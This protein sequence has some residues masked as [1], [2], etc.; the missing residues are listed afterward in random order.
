MSAAGVRVKR[1]RLRWN[2]EVGPWGNGFDHGWRDAHRGVSFGGTMSV[3]HPVA[4]DTAAAADYR[5][6][7]LEAQGVVDGGPMVRKLEGGGTS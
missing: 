1:R 7:Y 5:R 6:A 3:R 2:P 4:K